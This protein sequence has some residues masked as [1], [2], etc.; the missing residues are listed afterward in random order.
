MKLYTRLYG[1]I[2]VHMGPYGWPEVK[3][4]N[5]EKWKTNHQLSRYFSRAN[6]RGWSHGRG[7][8]ACKVTY[9]M[10]DRPWFRRHVI[11][12]RGDI[13]EMRG[14]VVR[15]TAPLNMMPKSWF[16]IDTCQRYGIIDCHRTWSG[17][18]DWFSIDFPSQ[19]ALTMCFVLPRKSIMWTSLSRRPA[20]TQ[21]N[22]AALL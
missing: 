7:M 2:W 8:R 11:R 20:A 9:W 16:N 22:T 15:T 14:Y 17:M 1:S 19:I 4:N 13:G 5:L 10:Q 6:S 21:G 12:G 18:V 3:Q